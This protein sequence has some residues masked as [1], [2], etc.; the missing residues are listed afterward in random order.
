MNIFSYVNGEKN[1]VEKYYYI[2]NFIFILFSQKQTNTIY[3]NTIYLKCAISF[4]FGNSSKFYA[5]NTK[6]EI[7]IYLISI[8]LNFE[9]NNCIC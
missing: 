3:N 4:L 9:K 1:D 6:R 2:F 8:D 5:N 7:K